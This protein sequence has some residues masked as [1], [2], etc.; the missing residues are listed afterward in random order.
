M[1][2]FQGVI[3]IAK[4]TAWFGSVV[5]SFSGGEKKNILP[6]LKFL[7]QPYSN[8]SWKVCH[9]MGAPAEKLRWQL[10]KNQ[11]FESLYLLFKK[12]EGFPSQKSHVA[13][14][15][16]VPWRIS[17]HVTGTTPHQRGFQKTSTPRNPGNSRGSAIRWELTNIMAVCF[18]YLKIF[19]SKSWN[20]SKKKNVLNKSYIFAAF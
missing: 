20:F 11:P 17:S 16:E 6:P 19:K 9:E 18:H 2:I 1:L 14:S 5:T 4:L 13:F 15:G 7:F 12:M 3:F 8:Q 10:R